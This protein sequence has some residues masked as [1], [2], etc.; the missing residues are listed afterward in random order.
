MIPEVSL[1]FLV[2]VL[3]LVVGV[4]SGLLGI[5]GGVVM[6]PMLLLVPPVVGLGALG[7]ASVTGITAMQSFAAAAFS[8]WAHAGRGRVDRKLIFGLGPPMW[9]AAL[10]GSWLGG[11]MP[12]RVLEGVLTSL[13]SAAALLLVRPKDGSSGSQEAVSWTGFSPGRGPH[14]R[15][16]RRTVRRDR[17]RWRVSLSTGHGSAHE[18]PHA[19]GR[20]YRCIRR[21][22]QRGPDHDGASRRWTHAVG[23]GARHSAKP[24]TRDARW[25]RFQLSG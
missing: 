12:P 17:P 6:A 2:A 18:G 1:I 16:H 7:M 11:G 14:R 15:R 13:M 25:S 4:L 22:S 20:R 3:A 9:V 5:G 21:D 10:V 24:G 8:A 19:P 23:S